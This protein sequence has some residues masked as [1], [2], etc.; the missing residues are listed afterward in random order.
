MMKTHSLDW[1]AL[2]MAV[3]LPTACG[4]TSDES[5][6]PTTQ[7]EAALHG[8]SRDGAVF[9]MSNDAQAN[10]VFAYHRSADG[11]LDAA[12]QYATGGLGTGASLGS[13][14]SVT[15]SEDGRF[16]LVV[17]AGSN[18]ISSFV[19]RGT[20]LTLRS[21][22]P[23]GGM[24]PTSIAER[25]HLVYVLNAG[26]NSN[27]SGFWLDAW[28]RLQP[29]AGST[30]ALS[31][32][33]PSA[34]E[35]AIAPRGLGVVVTEKGTNLIDVFGLHLNGTLGNLETH[36][37]SGAVPYGF[38]F[39]SSGTLVVSEAAPGA[40][41]SYRLDRA[42]AFSTISASVADNQKAPCWVVVTHDGRFAYTANAGS[43]SISGY[44]LARDGALQL[45][46]ANG[47]TGDM[48]QNAK[49]L[50]M[51]LDQSRHL[52]AID[53]ANHVIDGFSIGEKG[54]LTPVTSAT[55]LPSTLVGVAAL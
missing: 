34:A 29:I 32:A 3:A 46:D 55:G 13:Q 51:A 21:K 6:S 5:E 31:A 26:S 49:P 36:A 28:G 45:L 24:M 47:V 54:S 4:G 19:V 16:L 40:V 11:S 30:R 20:H 17:N 2:A 18:D 1:C 27:I 42:G 9:T 43:S 14:G 38:D 10:T 12:A 15:L 7:G 37:S 52:Y 23:S 53:A 41:S 35:V 44:S 8:E 50:D 33:M 22:V 48:G 39:S 25:D